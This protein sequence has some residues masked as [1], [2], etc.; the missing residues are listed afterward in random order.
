MMICHKSEFTVTVFPF[1]G[2]F[3]PDRSI[4]MLRLFSE[5]EKG[6]EKKLFWAN[7]TIIVELQVVLVYFRFPN[8]VIGVTYGRKK[9]ATYPV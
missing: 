2:V 5:R 7:C 1:V 3:G 8:L 9:K 6:K 4:F